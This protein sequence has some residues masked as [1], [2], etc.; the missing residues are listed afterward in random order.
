MRIFVKESLLSR[1]IDMAASASVFVSAAQLSL[2]L[3][4]SI[5][6]RPCAAKRFAPPRRELT[7]TE[8]PAALL[9]AL[10][11]PCEDDPKSV[12]SGIPHIE[13]L[14]GTCSQDIV[15]LLTMKPPP[16]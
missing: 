9:A 5:F 4:L 3:L 8:G 1:V 11:Y 14:F 6:A 10:Q 16:N 12:C 2:L 15:S 13:A 7:V